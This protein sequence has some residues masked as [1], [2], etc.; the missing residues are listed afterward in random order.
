MSK[1]TII[2]CDLCGDRI[3]R[4]G[5]KVGKGAI[6]FRAK[7]LHLK[8]DGL[9]RELSPIFYPGW[10]RTRYHICPKCVEKIKTLCKGG[11]ED[12]ECPESC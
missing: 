8:L 5:W 11:G 3:Y 6:T 7:E 9:T 12:A 4:D 2:C 10:V 1:H